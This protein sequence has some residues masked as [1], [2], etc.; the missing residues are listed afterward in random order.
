MKFALGLDVCRV[1]GLCGIEYAKVNLLLVDRYLSSIPS[2]VMTMNAK[3]TNGIVR[4]FC[5]AILLIQRVIALADIFN[6]VVAAY[7][8][9][10]V[11]NFT[12]P[13]SVNIEPSQS[14]SHV[15]N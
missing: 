12:R 15:L 1:R 7:P 14:M 4:C 6:S 8:V 2:I 3:R 11:K 5:P 9:S 10:M 13:F